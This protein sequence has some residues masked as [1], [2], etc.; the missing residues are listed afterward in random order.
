[1]RLEA[2]PNESYLSAF[3]SSTS[4]GFMVLGLASTG[5]L[6]AFLLAVTGRG[7]QIEESLLESQRLAQSLAQSREQLQKG[8]EQFR[9][10]AETIPHLIWMGDASGKI[11]FFNKR[12]TEYTG[13]SLESSLGAPGVLH[14]DDLNE[15]LAHWQKAIGSRSL[16]N[17]E[18]RLRRHDGQYRWQ[19]ARALPWLDA[20]GNVLRWFGSCTDVHEQKV[21]GQELESANRSLELAHQTP[22]IGTWEYDFEKNVLTRTP[23]H[24]KLY[25]LDVMLAEWNIENFLRLIHPDDR[26]MVVS[27]I[28]QAKENNVDDYSMEYRVVWPDQSVHLL[29]F[30]AHSIRGKNGEITSQCGTVFDV[31]NIRSLQAE[32]LELEI[33]EKSAQE[34]ARLKSEFLALMSHEIRTLLNGVIGMTNLLLDTVLNAEQHGYATAVKRSGDSLLTIINDIL[35]F[36]KI[37]AGKL[38]FEE[39][40]FSLNQ[41][42]E[43]TR[44]PLARMAVE[45]GLVL[46]YRV[47][48]G[49]PEDVIGDPGRIRQVLTNLLSNALKFTHRGSAR[50]NIQSCL[51][52]PHK[53]TLVFEVCDTGIG[54]SEASK[55]RLFILMDCLMPELD[56]FEATLRIRESSTLRNPGIPIVAMTANAMKS[57]VEKCLMAGM[58][59]HVTKPVEW[60]ALDSV[61][62]RLLA[63]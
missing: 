51:S 19:L 47:D 2:T 33:R 13:L 12:W 4:W 26:P 48:A 22:Q 56:G 10:L 60:K 59:A 45:K 63:S 40:N 35:D 44:I 38:D 39:M 32:R 49:V 14:E 25:G 16:F 5:F 37:E 43:D 46:D 34:S 54:I 3:T 31:T 24:D 53:S 27:A 52:G 7:I 36:S 30:R 18:Y 6:G 50:M 29:S 23:F 17:M 62:K 21:K 20:N 42:L 28:T 41:L 58:N 1:M 15:V 55:G 8:E 11:D 61:L 57:D 9:F